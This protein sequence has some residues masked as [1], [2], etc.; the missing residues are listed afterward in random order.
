MAYIYIKNGIGKDKIIPYNIEAPIILYN[1]HIKEIYYSFIKSKSNLFEDE[2][3]YEGITTNLKK[4]IDGCQ[5]SQ[6]S[7]F[8]KSANV[9]EIVAIY[10][11]VLNYIV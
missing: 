3:Y 8:L 1:V 4:F 11:E 2:Y 9:Q 6:A 10:S 5:K 7:K